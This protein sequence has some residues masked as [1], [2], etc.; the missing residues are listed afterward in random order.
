MSRQIALGRIALFF[1]LVAVLNGV[2]AAAT[3]TLKADGTGDYPTIQAAIDAVSDGDEIV[4]APGTYTGQGNRDID[5]RGKAIT[6]RSA[7]PYDAD[8]VAA[9]VID[10]QG[11]RDEPH[12]GL[13]LRY[14]RPPGATL[15]G[16]TISNGW[17]RWGG[18]VYCGSSSLTIADCIF[19]N[20]TAEVA[21][22]AVCFEGGGALTILRCLIAENC[23]EDGGEGAG[24]YA[25]YGRITVKRSLF[26]GNEV[27]RWGQ[28][29]A[30]CC[31]G[32]TVEVLHC[33]ILDCL[34][35]RYGRS[36]GIYCGYG[37]D[38]TV[39]HSILWGL[40][41]SIYVYR[42]GARATVNWSLVQGGWE[43]TGNLCADPRLTP[44]GHLRADSPCIDAG[45]PGS[46][47]GQGEVDVDGEPVP[48]A[49]SVDLGADEFVDADADGLA[50]S[51][52]RRH[53]GSL[54]PEP[55]ADA[56]ADSA[57]NLEE[58]N[59]STEPLQ[60]L[61]TL[62]VDPV[63]GNDVWDGLASTWDGVHGPK[64]TIQAA[65]D[66]AAPDRGDRLI[67]LPGIYTGPGNRDLDLKG[68]IITL[69]STDPADPNIVAAT[70]IDCQGSEAEPH[71]GFDLH[72]GETPATVITGI[73]ITNGFGLY[74]ENALSEE[75]SAGG[76]IYCYRSSPTIR[77]CVITG[78]ETGFPNL[79]GAGIYCEGASPRIIRCTITQNVDPSGAGG[80]G[81]IR[82]SPYSAPAILNCTIRNN[83]GSGIGCRG[84]GSNAV[85]RNCLIQ[86]NSYGGVDA[87]SSSRP[88]LRNCT[89]THNG[90]GGVRCVDES[91]T[92]VTNCIIQENSPGQIQ[93]LDADVLVRY[94][95]VQG[96][97]PG[98]GNVDAD[99]LLTRDGRLCAA[100]PCI[101][102]GEPTVALEGAEGDIDG[103]PRVAGARIDIGADE[104]IDRD[105]DGLPDWWEQKYFGSPTAA[106]PSQDMDL[107]AHAN[108]QE[109]AA[110]SDPFKGPVTYYVDPSHGDD[111]WDGLTPA[112]DG[113]HGPKA[114]VQAAIDVAA[115]CEGDVV[116]LAP[117]GYLG[118][119]NRDID[120]RGKRLTVR[121]TDPDDPAVV[122]ATVI[123]CQG[124]RSSPHR[125]FYFHS[126]E[127]RDSVL[128]GLTITG[129]SG[130]RGGAVFCL[131]SSPT[132]VG[133]VFVD[134]DAGDPWGYGRGGAIYALY[135]APE[136]RQ[137]TIRGNSAPYGGAIMLGPGSNAVVAQCRIENNITYEWPGGAVSVSGSSLLIRDCLLSG[138]S[139]RA[140]SCGEGSRAVIEH[141][142]ITDNRDGGVYCQGGAPILKHCAIYSNGGYAFYNGAPSDIDAADCYWGTTDHEQ[143][144]AAIYDSDD[145]PSKGRV[146]WWPYTPDFDGNG[147]V[148]IFD[149]IYIVD[150][151]A[152]VEPNLAADVNRDGFVDLRDLIRVI[153]RFGW[154][155]P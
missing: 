96:G 100:S 14:V 130:L 53:F 126:A 114:T 18:G 58:Y 11:S 48:A 94:S 50:D 87:R 80:G 32:G 115:P 2:A 29:G 77:N 3:I 138:N 69:Q 39:R 59:R 49:G 1:A 27:G 113:T 98:E 60:P 17:A 84:P 120:F 154:Q 99:C 155:A 41:P 83:T 117:G 82:C 112:W 111:R 93:L 64:A 25:D 28:G 47:T 81:G 21:G 12:G 56:D 57:S 9:T 91:A 52:E 8:I 10:C 132:L 104:F 103:E 144:A 89:I 86:G 76:G 24:L 5:F 20:N 102:A 142:R 147:R 116:V 143:I 146:L 75:W 35:E 131:A 71:C 141:C 15:A 137:C 31:Y 118:P 16:L 127:R 22:G 88:T 33:T 145:D 90:L 42:E 74:R 139:R 95:A 122:A 63:R 105:A 34:G 119:G 55:Q 107:D 44:D 129:G 152:R 6:L 30:I 148:D 46:Q 61:A 68:K 134:N 150:E 108:L 26:R 67:L 38:L 123:D 66:A 19:R 92:T 65:I 4:L 72:D 140:I 13:S 85:I 121:S 106:E 51:W 149:V 153:N 151:F 128:A 36:E 43:G 37:S 23:V 45:Q 109:Y 135:G 136:I 73:T 79:G 54:A 78:N 124:S 101:D 7:D 40:G 70:V 133:C 62:Y 97:W 125:G 110:A